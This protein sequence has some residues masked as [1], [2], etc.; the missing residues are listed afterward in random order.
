M[1]IR[2]YTKGDEKAICE[3]FKAVFNKEMTLD[4]WNWRYANN[5]T[6]LQ[7]ISL[8]WDED[9]LA[10]HYA[11]SPTQMELNGEKILSGM[12]MTTMTH[13]DYRGLGIFPVLAEHLYREQAVEHGLSFA[14]GFPNSNSHYIFSKVLK[15]KDVEQIPTFSLFVDGFKSLTSSNSIRNGI[16]FKND[17]QEF[18]PA[19]EGELRV[20]KSQSYLQWRYIDNPVADYHVFTLEFDG[21]ICYAI[22]KLFNSFDFND[23][24]EIDIVELNFPDDYKSIS[25]LI[26]SILSFYGTENPVR[27]NM[28]LPLNRKNHL[29]FEKIGFVNTAP[30][31]YLGYRVLGQDINHNVKQWS[32]QMGDSDVY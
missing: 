5:P 25:E 2:S 20:F 19:A 22:T 17:I 28:W 12:S 32:Y 31:T 15:W 8:M 11:F 30:V 4:Y 23:R 18:R 27:I 9:K 3:L 7:M 21:K 10:G 1:E 24:V 29:L 13:P 6:G 14:W 16:D 26:S